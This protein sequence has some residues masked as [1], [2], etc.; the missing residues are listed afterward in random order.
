MRQIS[1]RLF[2]VFLA[3]IVVV[4]MVPS[5]VIS[6]SAANPVLV[7]VS[8][9]TG[10]AGENVVVS[11]NISANSGLA[12]A[13][14]FLKYDNTKLN[15]KSRALGIAA[16]GSL[17]AS[18]SPYT[19]NGNFT[20]IHFSVVNSVGINAAGSL[21][22]IT[23]TVKSVWI[24]IT[25]L[26]LTV[27]DFY[28]AALNLIIPVIKP[29]NITVNN[30][31]PYVTGDII[32][33]GS[34]PQT[35]VTDT[36]LIIALNA[37]PLGA[38]GTANY[39]GNRYKRSYFT[40][41]LPGYTTWPPDEFHSNQPNNGYFINTVYWFKYEPIEWQV[42]SNTNSELFVMAEK[43]LAS[44]AYD[45]DDIDVTGENYTLRSWL[46]NDFYNTAFNSTEHAKIKTSAVVNA[47]NPIWGTEGG[48]TT[49]DKLFLLSYSEVMNPAFGF[50]SSH[51]TYDT[52]RRAQGTDFAKSEGLSVYPDSPYL[53]NSC[54]W[55]RSPG[56]TSGY[57][58]IIGDGGD[59]GGDTEYINSTCIGVRPALKL[60]LTSDIFPSLDT[61]SNVKA[62]SRSNSS[63]KIT[64]AAVNGAAGYIVY[65]AETKN[66]DYKKINDTNK[67]SYTAT[68]LATG[69][70]YYFKV[71]AYA[72]I[73]GT[74]F[75][76]GFSSAAYA[77]P[78][79]DQYEDFFNMLDYSGASIPI[80]G[81]DTQYVPQG[82]CED[83]TNIYITAYYK[84][85]ENEEDGKNSKI[86]IINK[87]TGELTKALFV[88]SGAHFGGITVVGDELWICRGE[89]FLIVR[90][91]TVEG[92]SDGD[93]IAISE[94]YTADV[95]STLKDSAS[96]CYYD[97]SLLWVGVFTKVF[98]SKMIG[99]KI[100]SLSDGTYPLEKKYKIKIPM[101]IQG[102]VRLD[103]GSF[104]FTGSYGRDND[105]KIYKTLDG[106]KDK[107]SGDEFNI[108]YAFLTLEVPPMA[109]G[110]SLNSNNE[111]RILFESGADC[112]YGHPDAYGSSN[113]CDYPVFHVLTID[114]N[115]VS[116]KNSGKAFNNSAIIPKNAMP[117][118]SAYAGEVPQETAIT[119]VCGENAN[120]SF[121]PATGALAVTGTGRIFD[122]APYEDIPAPWEEYSNAI[123]T[124]DVAPGITGIGVYSFSGCT[125]LSSISIPASVT[126]IGDGAFSCCAALASINGCNGVLSIGDHAFSECAALTGFSIPGTLETLGRYVFESCGMLVNINVD[127]GNEVFSSVNG[128][129]TSKDESTIIICPEGKTG[130][131]AVSSVIT[132]IA[133]DAFSNCS[134]LTAIY[135]PDSVVSIGE[136]AFYG[137]SGLKDI[138]VPQSVVVIGE[139]AFTACYDLIDIE[140]DSINSLF[141]SI[142]GCLYSKDES[143]LL[144]CPEGKTGS[145]V[146][147]ENVTSIGDSAFYGCDVV[148]IAGMA[149][150]VAETYAAENGFTFLCIVQGLNLVDL[151][152]KQTYALGETLDLA[153]LRLL[154]CGAGNSLSEISE[155][156]VSGFDSAAAGIKTVVLDYSGQSVSFV[157]EVREDAVLSS[158][159]PY[160]NNSDVSFAYTHPESASYLEV[161]FSEKTSTEYGND[162]ICIFDGNGNQT[163]EYSGS[164]L[165]ARKI[166]VPG[167]SMTVTLISDSSSTDFGFEVVSITALDTNPAGICENG[168][169]W[170]FDIAAETLEISGSGALNAYAGDTA[171][172]YSFRYDIKSV[173]IG[174]GVSAIDNN[175]FSGLDAL[176][177]ITVDAGNS[178]F[179]SVDGAVYSDNVDALLLCPPGK[180]GQL[181]IP[182]SVTAI[183]DAAVKG[184]AGLTYVIVP[185]SVTEIPEN[186]FEG[187]GEVTFIG[188]SGSSAENY[189]K[190]NGFAFIHPGMNLLELPEKDVYSLGE[191]LNLSG[192]RLVY[193][194]GLYNLTELSD[195]HVAG[196]QPQMMGSQVIDLLYSGEKAS[197][198]VTVGAAVL[199]SSHPY[200]N[201]SN[202]EWI[203]VHPENAEF[204]EVMFSQT[205]RSEPGFDFFKV[206][207]GS[208]NLIGEYTGAELAGRMIAV[209]GN[210][211]K[212]I[213]TSDSDISD[214]GFDACVQ[215]FNGSAAGICGDDVN[216]SFDFAS[217]TLALT[218]LGVMENYD[219]WTDNNAPW[220]YLKKY[221]ISATLAEGISTIGSCAFAGF[222][223]LV[224]IIL[225]DSVSN[226]GTGSFLNCANLSRIHIPDS[227]TGIGNQAFDGC[228]NLTIYSTSDS[229]AEVFTSARGITFE[230]YVS[231]VS[232]SNA[233]IDLSNRY[234][235]GLEP[236]TSALNG[237]ISTADGYELICV[238][239]SNGFG[240][241]ST[242]NITLDGIFIESYTIVIYGDLNGDGVIDTVDS[243][244]IVD[245]GNYVLPQWDPVTDAAYI[246]AGDLFRDGIMDENDCIVLMDVQNFALN[247]DQRTGVAAAP[248]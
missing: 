77:R 109:E 167:N 40:Q 42:L 242:A 18:G 14:L 120:W 84:T 63:I 192:M 111:L 206:Y 95:S 147:R 163:G 239:S 160:A 144:R 128:I 173:H 202:L 101:Q 177:A 5:K 74:R 165:A 149:G 197:F 175:A 230:P 69:N 45:E 207:D 240:T 186:T 38:D 36:G 129:L 196:Y 39:G 35:K 23:F 200:E 72:D 116:S 189:S 150:S 209:P 53:G 184:C 37:Q 143:S 231:V 236:G 123:E 237:F 221:I 73:N 79:P 214:Y 32:E 4:S 178:A 64:W 137:C 171:P 130:D 57:A 86:Y 7:S 48:N 172:W 28:N 204:V 168:L 6:I 136:N 19:V 201:G 68:N 67:L 125:V 9:V 52:A 217:G 55:L 70:K 198:T 126:D 100:K 155:F 224:S 78:N 34:Y 141:S 71:R 170:S 124:V 133:N 246:K 10:T 164:Q 134:A 115:S 212:I 27:G 65:R 1:K 88:A 140:V 17:L 194:D 203:Y 47:D 113:K 154:S 159:H 187:C 56:I 29:G 166:L 193:C 24:G 91:S 195:C 25:P 247:L 75:Y 210:S 103:D 179:T 16:A 222:E 3:I 26:S 118:A 87:D 148:T 31:A 131:M 219:D 105:S 156:S 114:G 94:C 233:L 232:S 208:G 121:E 243:D 238:S 245:I 190:T 107:K 138:T 104:I 81:L 244:M 76:G 2:S 220:S 12:A 188:E 127:S 216:W 50:S 13:D 112:Y 241:G 66:G 162:R 97:G 51:L 15:Y 234:I 83:E 43:M 218:G 92:K 227:V 117:A 191:P 169:E 199:S 145:V 110:I 33:F 180:V 211:V 44:S 183:R 20:S 46:N 176:N 106:V 98:C 142:D 132:D 139:N 153:G 60:N 96:F 80:P 135:I 93:T 185:A 21:L 119:G 41:Y 158:A 11:I 85:K 151:P 182:G 146:I 8:N 226:I 49:Y 90:K 61:V 62:V 82:I 30:Y 205:T 58:G 235:Y 181:E 174:G 248:G 59:I 99:Y 22:D 228:G 223:N 122:C 54:W 213:L 102:C 215:V 108:D 89:G 157:I 161:E 152:V 225:P 229:Y